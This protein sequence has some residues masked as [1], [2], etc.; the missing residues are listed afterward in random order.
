ML[1]HD[2]RVIHSNGPWRVLAQRFEVM[3][4]DGTAVQLHPVLQGDVPMP[5]LRAVH[6]EGLRWIVLDLRRHGREIEADLKSSLERDAPGIVFYTLRAAHRSA[7]EFLDHIAMHH[8]HAW[9][10]APAAEAA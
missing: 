5:M 10:Q 4:H 7:R 8:V 9:W 2:T 1:H 3:F 6:H